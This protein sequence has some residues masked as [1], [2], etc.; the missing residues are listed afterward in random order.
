MTTQDLLSIVDSLHQGVNP[1]T[2]ERCKANSCLSNSAVKSALTRVRT[3]TLQQTR[4]STSILDATV[5]SELIDDLKRIGFA[6]TTNQ[7]SK[8]FR[9]SRTV[10]SLEL[11]ALPAYG[12]YKGVYSSRTLVKIITEM[13]ESEKWEL[14]P[15]SLSGSKDLPRAAKEK[16]P[17]QDEPFF[18][19]EA[20]NHLDPALIQ[21]FADQI[22]SLGLRKP[23]EKLPL[24]MSQARNTLPRAFEP[25]TNAEKA[26]LVEAMCYTNQAG[27]LAEIFGRSANALRSE[28]KR[29][30]YTSRQQ[31]A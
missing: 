17:W 29:L 19:E 15:R 23:T 8:I 6:A 1:L 3:I 28:G 2:G 11:R 5:V 12:K 26:L 16:Q 4:V 24:Y 20:F 10:V 14:Q 22:E 18:N 21:N 13:N 31:R 27:K 30:I 7:L 9:G 25:W